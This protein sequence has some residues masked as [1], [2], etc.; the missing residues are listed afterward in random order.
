MPKHTG[1]PGTQTRLSLPTSS[2]SHRL[3][4]RLKEAK[5][6]GSFPSGSGIEFIRDRIYVVGDDARDVLVLNKKLETL[7]RIALL[8]GKGKR[9]AKTAK[10]DLEATATVT[11][12][13]TPHLLA[14]GSGSRPNRTL[15]VLMNVDNCAFEFIDLAAFFARLPAT[16]I[17]ETNIEGATAVGERL[18]LA[19]RGNKRHPGNQLV[20][21]AAEFWRYPAAT[22]LRSY[23]LD[24]TAHAPLAGV[25]GLAYAQHHDCLCL[26]A[27]TED[28]SNN[29]DDGAIGN[30][31]LGLIFSASQVLR[32]RRRVIAC[33]FVINLAQSHAAFA[34]QK[35]ESLC[36]TKST[37]TG[38][39]LYLVADNDS[40]KTHLFKA[41]LLFATGK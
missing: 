37:P 38:L 1:H 30:S 15:A 41:R 32:S 31:Y 16:G 39:T 24:L 14:I 26:T 6:I 33:D 35:I 19:N 9:I 28:T 3:R 29:Y 8:P 22:G 2:P 17:A 13:G 7:Q 23:A 36:I 25:S 27:S 4:L 11:P 40:G 5:C 20:V 34:G 12:G 18:V 10:A 21:T